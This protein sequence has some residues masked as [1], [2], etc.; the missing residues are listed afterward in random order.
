MQPRGRPSSPEYRGSHSFIVC[1]LFDSLSTSTY[2]ANWLA[3]IKA[4][5][6]E[7]NHLAAEHDSALMSAYL[8]N[9]TLLLH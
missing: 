9:E 7:A 6:T 5:N 4:E 8:L 3:D 2:P 1:P